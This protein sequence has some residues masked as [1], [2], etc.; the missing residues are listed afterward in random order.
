MH[1]R[2]QALSTRSSEH[3][4]HRDMRQAKGRRTAL[5]ISVSILAPAGKESGADQRV[6]ARASSHGNHGKNGF[7]RVESPLS[8]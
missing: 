1:V 5:A 2:R 3:N 4:D 7:H 8:A 6:P